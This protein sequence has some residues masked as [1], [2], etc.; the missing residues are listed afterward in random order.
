M[1]IREKLVKRLRKAGLSL[2][3]G[4]IAALE[5]YFELL[6]K[7]NAKVSLTSLPLA[8]DGEE[9]IDR[10]LVEPVLAAQYLPR[11]AA[12]VMDI[13]SGGGSPA[14]PIKI[15]SPAISLRMVESKTRKAAFL[16]E[17][18]RQLELRGA[19]V[20]TSRL[21]GLLIRPELHESADV[22]TVRAVRMERKLLAGIQAFLKP[23]GILML[24]RSG[25]VETDSALSNDLLQWEASYPL[26]S[27]L[28]SRLV[29]LRNVPRGTFAR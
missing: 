2:P 14:I 3:T 12:M 25:D 6:K 16:R 10:L 11:P 17:S 29:V 24:F 13:G 23:G 9:A 4:T 7:W 21:E 1:A 27:H 19:T 18:I 15:A 22:V 5:A 28:Q 26:L 8:S 20:E